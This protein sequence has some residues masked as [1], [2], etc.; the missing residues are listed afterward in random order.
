MLRYT[1]IY[2]LLFRI[3]LISFVGLPIIYLFTLITDKLRPSTP[4]LIILIVVFMGVI[5]GVAY[6][7]SISIGWIPT[8]LYVRLTLSTKIS[9]SEAKN[10]SFLFDGSLSNG[11]WYPLYD[12]KELKP[13]SRKEALFQFARRITI[14]GT[15]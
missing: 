2:D 1:H 10:L 8:Y 15:K 7:I 4:V 6:L 12:I 11:K 3:A 5:M 13:E 9:P 14:T